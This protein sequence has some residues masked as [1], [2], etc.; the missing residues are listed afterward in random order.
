MKRGTCAGARRRRQ[1]KPRRRG[2]R[3]RPPGRCSLRD[4]IAACVQ[5]RHDSP[6]GQHH[7]RAATAPLDQLSDAELSACCDAHL[8]DEALAA[9]MAPIDKWTDSQQAPDWPL[10]AEHLN[11]F[12]GSSWPAPPWDG[13]QVATV[14]L[15]LEMSKECD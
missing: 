5:L 4:H 9:A 2:L 7:R 14:A 13:D 6:L 11:A 8:G 15:C 1:A 12:L 10:V 3:L